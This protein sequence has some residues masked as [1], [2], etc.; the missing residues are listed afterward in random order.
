MGSTTLMHQVIK[1]RLRIN[2]LYHTS[3]KAPSQ[4]KTRFD[5]IIF[6]QDTLHLAFLK[7]C[8]LCHSK[9]WMQKFFI[10]KSINLQSIIVFHSQLVIKELLF[11]FSLINNEI[12]G[13]SIVPNI[14]GAKWFVLFIN[15]CTHVSQIFLL[16]QKSD[17][18]NV[19]PNL[20]NMIKT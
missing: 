1:I 15:D 16:K 13:L 20:H 4:I 11:L 2:F 6:D 17:V 7:S 12:W 8:F 3:P 10:V 19:F 9:N 14:S 18:R 5:F